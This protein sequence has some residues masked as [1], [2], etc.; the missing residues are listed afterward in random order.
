[1]LRG[2]LDSLRMPLWKDNRRGDGAGDVR[3]TR[4]GAKREP[5]AT[6]DFRALANC[7]LTG[8]INTGVA[9]RAEIAL[10]QLARRRV[11]Q[12]HDPQAALATDLS[13]R[14]AVTVVVL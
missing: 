14:F 7:R 2:W 11:A 8:Q 12:C 4:V 9:Q 6:N 10:I 13:N 5:A 3:Q 1:M